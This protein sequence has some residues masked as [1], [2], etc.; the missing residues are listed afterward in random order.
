MVAVQSPG[1]HAEA[2]ANRFEFCE[3]PTV[4]FRASY[5]RITYRSRSI[6]LS[7][8]VHAACDDYFAQNT[9]ALLGVQLPPCDILNNYLSGN[10]LADTVFTGPD[11][12]TMVGSSIEF[13]VLSLYL[14]NAPLTNYLTSPVP[15]TFQSRSFRSTSLRGLWGQ[16]PAHFFSAIT[17]EPLE[18]AQIA[19][20]CCLMM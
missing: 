5:T 8:Q 15:A 20:F 11:S 17:N 7:P 9:G 14:L 1:F 13:A 18:V 10:P 3:S 16:F 19:T 6:L 12:Y 2:C 4:W